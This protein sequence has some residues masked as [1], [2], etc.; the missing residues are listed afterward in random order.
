M[1]LLKRVSQ[2]PDVNLTSLIDVVFLLLIFFMVSTTFQRE[3]EINVQLP[4]A[5]GEALKTEK[6]VLEVTID[7]QGRYYVN[8][9]EVVNTQIETLKRAMQKAVGKETAPQVILSADQQTPHQAVMTAMDAAGQLG[10]VNITIAA[11][12]PKGP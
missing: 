4:E 10:F 2:E 5:S 1:K 9:Q 7:A 6:T 12:Q 8:Q 3:T 11:T